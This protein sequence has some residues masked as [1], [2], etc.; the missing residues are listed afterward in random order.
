MAP[1]S[2]MPMALAFSTKFVSSCAVITPSWFVS[3]I[4]KSWCFSR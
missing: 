4:W 3:M 1:A 2:G